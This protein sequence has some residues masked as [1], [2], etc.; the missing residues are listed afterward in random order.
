MM[1]QAHAAFAEAD[2][3]LS[4][5]ADFDAGIIDWD[6]R[7]I[8]TIRAIK[9]PQQL[10]AKYLGTLTAEIRIGSRTATL[11]IRDVMQQLDQLKPETQQ[12]VTQALT[13][14]S[15][16]FNIVSP[17]GYFRLHYDT[18]GANAVPTAD[19][20]TNGVPDYV[21]QCA[22]Y[23]DTS[24]DVHIQLGY[25]LPPSDGTLG[26]D[27]LFDIYFE[28]MSYYGYAIPEGSGPNAWNDA[29]S[30][31]VLNNN[32]V[33]FPPNNDPEG[34]VPG[35][36]K[37]TAVH[38]FHHCVQFAY[39][40]SEASWFM[41][42]DATYLEDIGFN[43]V[44]DNYNYLSSFFT[45][46]YKSLM[47][48]SLHM[49]SCFIWELYLAQKFDTSLMLSVWEGARY[50]DVFTTLSDSL[51]ANYGWTMDSAF[52][53]FALWNYMTLTRDDGLHH[54]E[55]ANY[56][57]IDYDRTYSGY[58]VTMQNTIASPAGYSAAY[59]QFFPGNSTGILNITFDGAD[60]DQWQAWLIKSTT[61]N[62]HEIEQIPLA[63]GAYSGT[64]EVFGFE[65]YYRITLA[66]INTSEFS[67]VGKKFAY[68]AFVTQPYAVSSVVL[69]TDS[70][71][72]SGG[73]RDFEY[74]VFNIAPIND[75]FYLVASDDLGWTGPDTQ[76]VAI[77]AGADSVVSFEVHPPQGTPI[78]T[79]ASLTFKVVS[80]GDSAVVD[81]QAVGGKAILQYG[82][83]NFNGTI[84]IEDLTYF[85]DFLFGGGSS[86]VP[87][88]E[89]GNFD[90]AGDV[91]IID[92]TSLVE[93][94]FGGGGAP[95]CNPY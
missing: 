83:S 74:Q 18:M 40:W 20:N 70:V 64:V 76:S 27:S 91:G 68:S 22:A 4:I 63:P 88:L 6:Q 56:P 42:L 30:H 59:I 79:T 72:Y 11:A 12:Q 69:T 50:D 62:Q 57:F 31:M 1:G 41:E 38:E 82:D 19:A 53:E 48:N 71:V 89:S 81:S 5:R 15:T 16:T 7:A 75:V 35:S 32:F 80:W 2:P 92:L 21:E 94:L 58:P 23:C 73:Y 24:L 14:F 29:Y 45:A 10:P 90:C 84:D 13:R 8:F 66:G 77:L 28:N 55:A 78:G 34:Q 67:S 54:E 43:Q 87:V 86:P 65:D 36:A 9:N 26:G 85:V 51:L 39:D 93:Y 25:L 46:P 52:T 47:E 37:A 61:N 33:G 95:P 17:S 44:D 60:S 49:Y 3:L